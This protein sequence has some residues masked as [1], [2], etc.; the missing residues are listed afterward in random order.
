M[1]MASQSTQVYKA[2]F[3]EKRQRGRNH[4]KTVN[5]KFQRRYCELTSD[6]LI[7]YKDMKVCRTMPFN[8]WP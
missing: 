7:Y 8:Q 5:L 4:P 2:G 1:A 6:G 3:L